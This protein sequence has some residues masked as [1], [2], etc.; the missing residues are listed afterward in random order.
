M[1]D[2]RDLRARLESLESQTAA[3]ASE[4]QRMDSDLARVRTKAQE[5]VETSKQA[6]GKI[7]SAVSRIRSVLHSNS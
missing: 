7:D 5:L 6:V 2:R 1:K 4:R 3:F